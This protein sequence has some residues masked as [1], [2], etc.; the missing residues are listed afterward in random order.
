[1][2][3]TMQRVCFLTLL[4]T[5]MGVLHAQENQNPKLYAVVFHAD[6]CPVCKA[7]KPS[8]TQLKE[9]LKNK[10]VR[11]VSFDFTSDAT[12]ANTKQVARDL[13]L[14]KILAGNNGTGFVILVNP[15]TEMEVGRLTRRQDE[16]EMLATVEKHL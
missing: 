2:R 12:K 5:G 11:F 7:M 3:K 14:Q 8:L 9:D 1:M 16:K 13:G 15:E 6:W 10:P 4:I